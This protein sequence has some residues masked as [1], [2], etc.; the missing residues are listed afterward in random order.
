M[1]NA[2]NMIVTALLA[3]IL[4]VP[5]VALAQT[6]PEWRRLFGETRYDTMS[7]IVSEGFSRSTRVV[8]ASGENF[9]DALA[10]S[11]LAGVLGCPTLIS[12]AF[13]LSPQAREQLVRLGTR[14]AFVVG[15]ASAVSDQ[16]V[17]AI[18]AMGIS[19]RR[20]AGDSRITTSLAVLDTMRELGTVSDTVI[21]ASGYSFADSLS[22]SPWAYANSSPILLALSDGT[23]DGRTVEAINTAGFKTAVVVGGPQAVSAATEEQLSIPVTR[24]AGPNRYETSRA[25][26]EWEVAH[27]LSLSSPALASGRDFPDALSGAALSGAKHSVLLLGNDVSHPTYQ[28]LEARKGECTVRY[29]LGGTSAVYFASNSDL[30]DISIPSPNNSGPRTY[31]IT[32]IT[33]HYMDEQW[34]AEECGLSFARPERE[35]SSNYGIGLEGEVGLYV[36]ESCRSWASSSAENDN[37]AITIECACLPDSSLTDATWDSLVDLCVD[38]CQRNGI[39]RLNFTGDETGNLTMHKHFSPITVCPGPWLESRFDLLAEQV[40]ARLGR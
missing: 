35:A 9:P 7:A 17:D 14:E 2:V 4:C 32:K 1:R 30:V 27:G 24:L 19:C 8:I 28:W 23:L 37:R 38:I 11:A 18:S 12:A 22:I 16:V 33:P 34:S 40:N 21:I 15:G 25:V 39:A 36:D 5:S 13:D 29:L 20:I 6:A 26:A 31:P 3:T 10:A